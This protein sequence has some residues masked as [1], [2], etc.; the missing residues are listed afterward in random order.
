MDG[1]SGRILNI[2]EYPG[3]LDIV[4]MKLGHDLVYVQLNLGIA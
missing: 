1:K 3:A 2:G 4:E